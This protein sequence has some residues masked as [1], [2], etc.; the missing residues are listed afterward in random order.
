MHDGSDQKINRRTSATK[1]KLGLSK[2]RG[3]LFATLAESLIAILAAMVVGGLV[4]ALTGESPFIAYKELFLGS[5]GAKVSLANTLSKAIPLIFTGLSVAITAK[6][7][8]L[9][10]GAEGQLHLGAMASALLGL[11]LGQTPSWIAIPLL[12][13]AGFLGGFFGGGVAGILSSRFMVSE[14]IVAIM[15]NYIFILFTSYL[16]GGPFKSPGSVI[17]TDPIPETARLLKLIPKT[18]L[19]SAVFIAAGAIFLVYILLWKTTLGF[20]IRSVGANR[21]AANSAGINPSTYAIL[22]MALSGGVAGL[23]GSTEVLGKYYRF[24]EGFSPSFG[25][26]GIAIA[27]LGRSNPFGVLLTALLFGILETGSL[28]MARVTNVSSNIVTVIQSLVIISVATPEIFRFI[29]RTSEM[30]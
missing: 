18:Q 8:M 28:R 7:G 16:A 17:Q 1:G 6:C 2:I 9:N 29:R 26:T 10:I 30:K 24:I 15:L 4:I 25:F 5:L 21:F 22:T 3:N 11:A 12:I 14:V 27:I 13:A 23:A 20:K 19:T